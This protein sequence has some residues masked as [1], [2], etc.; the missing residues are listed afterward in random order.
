MKTRVHQERIEREE[1]DSFVLGGDVGGTN[2][3]I[4]VA[5]AKAGKTT[6]LYSAHFESRRLSSLAPAIREALDYGMDRYGIEVGRAS[7]ASRVPSQT[8]ERRSRR[9]SPGRWTP[10]R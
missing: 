5:G 4:G 3:N 10:R 2:T 1:Y 8:P 9:T 6:L 7:S